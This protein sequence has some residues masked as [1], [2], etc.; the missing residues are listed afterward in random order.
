MTQFPARD[1]QIRNMH[2]LLI[3]QVVKACHNEQERPLLDRLLTQAAQN[4]WTDLVDT[5]RRIVA[6]RRDES[7]LKGLDDEDRV[8]IQSIL[9]G[10]H[11]PNTLPDT[12]KQADPNMAA[13]GMAMMIHAARRGDPEAL[14]ALA[15]LAKQ[16]TQ[17]HGDMQQ[18]GG[19]MGKLVD[20]ERDVEQLTQRM[21]EQ[22]RKL[23][24]DIIAELKNMEH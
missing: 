21:G 19:I 4:G 1:E 13:P 11:D 23:V 17:S 8:I 5:I 3:H 24:Q 9:A 10:L 2:A 6:G 7:L 16:M 15:Y 14:Q 20:G 22:G 12:N 18:M